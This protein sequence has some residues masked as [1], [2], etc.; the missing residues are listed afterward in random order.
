MGQNLVLNMDDHGFTVRAC[1][2]LCTTCFCALR[3]QAS[4]PSSF[5]VP[6]LRFPGANVNTTRFR[7][8]ICSGGSLHV[9]MYSHLG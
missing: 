1:L 7:S 3:V 6:K 9:E 5:N 2:W 8:S 4:D